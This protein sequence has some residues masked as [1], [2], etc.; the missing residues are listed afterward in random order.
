MSRLSPAARHM[1]RVAAKQAATEAK[2]QMGTMADATVYEQYLAKLQ[3]DHLRLKQIQSAQGKGEL[4]KVLLPEYVDYIRGV[5]ESDAGV[6]DDVITTLMVW[7]M[8]AGEFESTALPIAEYVIKH[9]LKLPDRFERT[10]PTLIAEEIA[11]AA[12]N[13]QQ[14]GDGLALNDLLRTA[15][16]TDASDMP[17]QV[18]AKLYLAIGRANATIADRTEDAEA[19]ALWLDLARKYLAQAIDLHDRCGGKKDL[20]KVGRLL[21]KHAELKAQA[22]AKA[23]TDATEKPAN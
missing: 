2:A 7:A 19:S 15:S 14:S 10:A 1:A 18:R 17:D 13:G 16:M 23:E 9:N 4:K 22:E 6:P 5:L 12:L 11:E 8:D 21:K 20:E 3:Q